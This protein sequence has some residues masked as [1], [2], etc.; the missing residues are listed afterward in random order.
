MFRAVRGGV[1]QSS[2]EF[3]LHV[4]RGSCRIEASFRQEGVVRELRGKTVRLELYDTFWNETD[5]KCST[6]V[7]QRYATAGCEG[8]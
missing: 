3:A 2:P 7:P 8:S 1:Y 4:I 5:W 6:T